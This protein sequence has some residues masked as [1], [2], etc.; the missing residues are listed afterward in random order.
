MI[1]TLTYGWEAIGRHA[2]HQDSAAVMALKE[3]YAK[4]EARWHELS[5]AV[6]GMD[7]DAFTANCQQ[8]I[9]LSSK[10][11]RITAQIAEVEHAEKI[12]AD[13]TGRDADAA[14]LAEIQDG[15]RL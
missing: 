6:D 12:D 2:R 1:T 3:E 5:A 10:M 8:L 11:Q 7:G 9:S 15:W 4:I 14:D 13:R